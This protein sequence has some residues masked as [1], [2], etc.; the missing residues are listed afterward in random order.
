[1]CVCVCMRA[2]VFETVSI[3]LT[4]KFIALSGKETDVVDFLSVLFVF[5]LCVCW[6]RRGRGGGSCFGG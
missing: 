6:G 3:S 1:M 5:C 4:L 2:C